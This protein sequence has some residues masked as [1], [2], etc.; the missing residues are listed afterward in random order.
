M[1]L[2][3]APMMMAVS[4][5]APFPPLT[6]SSLI[7]RFA[8]VAISFPFRFYQGV[9]VTP[10]RDELCRVNE[11]TIG[12][13]RQL[14]RFTYLIGLIFYLVA[15]HRSTGMRP[16]SRSYARNAPHREGSYLITCSIVSM[17]DFH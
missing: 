10:H 9:S 5:L 11:L 8:L 4:G 16:C 17:S 7:F 1:A 12:A 15:A 14:T 6:K 3:A 2:V 13:Q